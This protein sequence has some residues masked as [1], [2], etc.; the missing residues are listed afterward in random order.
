[1]RGKMKLYP[2]KMRPDYHL[3]PWGGRIMK[4]MFR[5]NIPDGLVGESWEVSMH[6]GGMSRVD[7]GALK[8]M[9]LKA[10]VETYA[11]ELLGAAISS[12]YGRSFPLLV[13]LLDVNQLASVQVHPDDA[14]AMELEKFPSGK[15]E[16]W[17]IIAAKPGHQMFMGFKDGVGRAEFLAALPEGRAASLLNKIE[18]S[19][20]DC[21]Y[22]P[23]GTVHACGD[24]VFMLEIQQSCD[25]TYRVYDWDRVDQKGL[26]R[27]LHIEKAMRA[28][29]FKSRPQVFRATGA[30]NAL[31]SVLR[32][33]YFEV[34]ELVVASR[35]HLPPAETCRAGTLLQGD[36]LL[37]YQDGKLSLR[38]GDSFIV[39][40]G[41]PVAITSTSCNIV[42]TFPT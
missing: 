12:K 26:R 34:Q 21:V 22:V 3:K 4:D 37:E 17:Y 14:L 5:K 16:A 40:C 10:L 29:D 28:I 27:E 13:K 24:G 36:C 35:C 7:S 38:L 30:P 23:P 20:G 32:S 25:I 9:T 18:V 11:E 19:P 1:M 15:S 42:T 8:E 41:I 6:P 2:M 39:P 33:P 31:N